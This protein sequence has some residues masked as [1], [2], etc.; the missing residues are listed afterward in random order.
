MKNT[1]SSL[2]LFACSAMFL[3]CAA[4]ESQEGPQL[5]DEVGTSFA[6]Q[7]TVR[8]ERS[9]QGDQLSIIG[10][11]WTQSAPGVWQSGDSRMVV[12]AEGHRTAIALEEKRLSDL[13]KS[14]A[15]AATLLASENELARLRSAAASIKEPDPSTQVTCNIGFI[16]GPSSP[17]T[18]ATGVIAA[19]QI[20]CVDG[21]VAFTVQ[22][23]AC[24]NGG[25]TPVVSQSNPG[26]GP[27]GWT[28]G[29]VVNAPGGLPCTA[30]NVVTP[31]GVGSGWS[32]TCG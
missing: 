5:I 3:G 23:Q 13:Q 8:L 4:S 10:G 26:V 21:V 9:G 30:A 28:A 29:I 27:A 17:F 19:A 2:S 22:S 31:P 14:G 7:S 12:G 1:I 20:V 6:A 11:N 32:G 24:V 25:C 15:G 16:Q 18:G